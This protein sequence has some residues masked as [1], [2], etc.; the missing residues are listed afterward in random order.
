MRRSG[1]IN[2]SLRA[3]KVLYLDQHLTLW[4]LPYELR[5]GQSP[6]DIE[7]APR[8]HTC[9]G[10]CYG[11]GGGE[12]R[13]IPDDWI[14][15]G[16]C[17]SWGHLEIEQVEL[18]KAWLKTQHKL[19]YW[20]ESAAVEPLTEE[21]WARV[22]AEGATSASC[23]RAALAA[24]QRW[25]DAANRSLESWRPEILAAA[26]APEGLRRSDILSFTG[27]FSAADNAVVEGPGVLNFCAAVNELTRAGE[28][29]MEF[30]L[31]STGESLTPGATQA[32]I[33][34]AGCKTSKAAHDL[35]L[36][37]WRAVQPGP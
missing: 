27:V 21:Q 20:Y 3:V 8:P 17:G 10:R 6:R 25:V 19:G 34:A 24:A 30:F 2:W 5:P 31:R 18:A 26:A 12:P 37:V 23:R 1:D 22:E 7:R 32:A 35:I 29:R 15:L 9:T 11:C 4:G 16:N 13:G 14:Y 33:K 28:L 36:V